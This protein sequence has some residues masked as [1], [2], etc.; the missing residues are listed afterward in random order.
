V[1]AVL[2]LDDRVQAVPHIRQRPASETT[3][4]VALTALE[5]AH[6]YGLDAPQGRGSGRCVGIRAFNAPITFDPDSI[7]AGG[8]T[9]A[10][11]AAYA[12]L[13]RLDSAPL[14]QV[15]ACTGGR[16]S[17]VPVE[18]GQR[19]L[20]ARRPRLSCAAAATTTQAECMQRFGQTEQRTL[21]CAA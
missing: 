13:V 5:V 6:L 17:R 14:V 9:D 15:V 16:N 21:A 4:S 11:L 1:Q 8:F 2:G 19:V 3:T 20:D 10:D 18:R 7:R 12:R